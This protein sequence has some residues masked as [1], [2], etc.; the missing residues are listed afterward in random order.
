[1]ILFLKLI[2]LIILLIILIIFLIINNNYWYKICISS[3]NKDYYKWI[4]SDKYIAKK[5]A[6]KL[7]FNVPK[8]YLLTNNLDN[9]N[10]SKL[11]KQYVIKPVDLCDGAGVYLID[12][13]INK[14]T[15]KLI[16]KKQI[17]NQLKELRKNEKEY[18]MH[19]E[20]FNKIPFKG[21]IIEELLLDNKGNI[22]NDYKCYVFNGKIYFIVVLYD[23]KKINNKTIYKSVWM[24]RNWE[25]IYFKM[26][27]KNYHYR[28]LYKPNNLNKII[29][30]VEK[31]GKMLG[32][33]C[34]IDIYNINNK[35]YL[36]EFTF[37]CGAY[38]HT[39]FCNTILGLLWTKY[40]DTKKNINMIN[41]II[42]EYYNKI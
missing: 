34:R 41:D 1:M 3:K 25:P 28:K 42:P 37:F 15:D 2:V 7:G 35:I 39:I 9:I 16:N 31:T 36:G 40:P 11:P 5:F 17:V 23:R 10:F 18:Y 21:Y 19:Y 8:T 30:L 20:M 6:F 14:M 12:N 33:H 38:L 4:L 27:H 13:N 22:P 32:R 24:N 26:C 29:N